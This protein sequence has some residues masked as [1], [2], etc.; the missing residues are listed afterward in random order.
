MKDLHETVTS[1]FIQFSLFVILKLIFFLFRFYVMPVVEID[2]KTLDVL[3]SWIIDAYRLDFMLIFW[4]DDLQNA[5][6]E[7][8]EKLYRHSDEAE[9]EE[10]HLTMNQIQVYHICLF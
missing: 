7:D 9:E 1:I 6:I 4:T 8:I 10:K 3:H 5:A 2:I